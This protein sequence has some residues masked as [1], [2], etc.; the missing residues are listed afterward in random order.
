MKKITLLLI[1]CV[2]SLACAKAEPK[3][4]KIETPVSKP[5]VPTLEKWNTQYNFTL[6]NIN[7]GKEFSLSEF[8][9]KVIIVDFW[10]TWCPPCRQQVPV[11]N[12]LYEKYKSQGLEIVGVSLDR[13]GAKGVIDFTKK[14][15]M[16]YTV[17]MGDADVVSI[18][19]GITG[20]PTAFILDKKGNLVKKHIGYAEQEVLEEE[21]KDLF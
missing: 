9:G 14:Y 7:S 20:I 1:C 18:Y 3:P 13:D 21:I 15:K 8:A 16:Q 2:L 11:F 6:T 5:A 12:A 10:A 17:V 19:G 4:K